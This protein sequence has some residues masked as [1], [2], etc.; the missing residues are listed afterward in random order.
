MELIPA[1]DIMDGKCV[2]LTKGDFNKKTVYSNQPLE[3]AKVFEAAGLK[4]LHIVDLDGA[5]GQSL[6]NVDVLEN[7]AEKTSLIIDF[8][9]GLR[10][11]ENIKAVF[12]SGASMV[13]LGSVA[14]KKPDLFAQWV[15]DFGPGKF[16]PGADVLDKKIKIHGWKENTGIEIFNF[17][18]NL[19]ELNI[20]TIF[21][22]DISKDGMMQGPSVDLYK[23]IINEFPSLHLIASGGISCYEDLFVLQDAG[24]HGAIVGKAFYEGKITTQQIT[25]FIKNN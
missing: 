2:R 20:D 11:T 6:K 23:E 13:S 3:I 10:T 1:I 14:V 17:I 7:I 21:C 9:G 15:I 18:E 5:N 22:T 19:L 8:G 24:C 16:L 25:D 4:R 12:N